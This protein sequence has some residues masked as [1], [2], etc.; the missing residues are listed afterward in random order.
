MVVLH[1][2]VRTRH[3]RR[4]D[5]LLRL[6]SLLR[7]TKAHRIFI[8][9]RIIRLISEMRIAGRR[10]SDKRGKFSRF[11]AE[12]KSMLFLVPIHI[13]PAQRGR[14]LELKV[15]GECRLDFQRLLSFD[16]EQN[17]RARFVH[18]NTERFAHAERIARVQDRCG[19]GANGQRSRKA[20]GG[21]RPISNMKC[22]MKLTKNL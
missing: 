7:H 8:R 13:S 18:R 1:G 11:F 22:Q 17:D 16:V 4:D 9:R 21:Q 14:P 20:F 12:G 15:S 6:F 2:I 19:L 5:Q 10:R 3:R